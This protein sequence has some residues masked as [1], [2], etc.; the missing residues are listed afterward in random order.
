MP[1]K[2]RKASHEGEVVRKPGVLVISHGSP[3]EHWV[4]LVEAAVAEAAVDLPA[5]LPLACAFLETVEGRLMIQDGIDRLESQG[6][7]DMIVI[8][9]FVSS[10]STHIDEIAYALGVKDTPEK[11]T[12]LERF[13]VSARVF[14]GDPIDDGPLVAAM[15]WDKVKRLSVRPEQEVLLLVGHG[16]VH[17]GFLQRWERGMASL[18]AQAGELAGLAGGADYAL[19]NP[20]SVRSK[21]RYWSEQRGMDVIVAPLFLSAGYFT[22]VTI[23][24]R[25]EGLA[26]RYSGEALLPHPLAARWMS[27]QILNI[28]GS[29]TC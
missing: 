5:G 28:M 22:K 9:L 20:D 2:V 7:T 17:P 16:S 3:D 1:A 18:A 11:E 12:D 26:H 6:V 29:L 25:L 14:F 19:L 10:G 27:Q 13:R 8:P 24:K 21:M 23:P 15:V 4:A